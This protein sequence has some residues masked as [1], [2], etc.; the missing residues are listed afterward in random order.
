MQQAEPCLLCGFGA[1]PVSWEAPPLDF[2]G[3]LPCVSDLKTIPCP[4]G[5]GIQVVDVWDSLEP[6]SDLLVALRR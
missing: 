6:V 3:E 5:S 4:C 2:I 1:E